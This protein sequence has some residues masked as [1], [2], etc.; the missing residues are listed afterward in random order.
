MTDA[1]TASQQVEG[2]L[3]R[4]HERMPADTREVTGALVR[5]PLEA[6]DRRLAFELE[7]DESHLQ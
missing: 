5:R 3:V 2:E 1:A 6:F 7:V 4:S